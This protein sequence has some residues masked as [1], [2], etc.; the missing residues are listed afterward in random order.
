MEQKSAPPS[1]D[2]AGDLTSAA[3]HIRSSW[4]HG[5]EAAEDVQ[6]VARKSWHDLSAD[7]DCYVKA[8]PKTVALGA[9]GAGLVLGYLSGAFSNRCRPA[10]PRP[11]AEG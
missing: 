1:G 3:E 4:E 6:H 8:R 7:I 11:E 10:A 9:L 5:K 2:R